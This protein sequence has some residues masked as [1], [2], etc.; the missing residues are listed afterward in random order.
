MKEVSLPSGAVL[1]I[2]PAPFSDAKE[3]Y[4][5]VAREVRTVHLN[6]KMEMAEVYKDIFCAGITSR[7]VEACLWKCFQKCLY[8]D[9]KIGKDTFEPVQAREDYTMICMEVAKENIHPFV[10]SLLSEFGP[11]LELLKADLK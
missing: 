7:E 9:L 11:I 10:K 6:N 2:T 5:A 1:K 8:N 3:L 4:Q